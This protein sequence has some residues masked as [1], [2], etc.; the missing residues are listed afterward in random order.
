MQ[1]RNFSGAGRRWWL[2][3]GAALLAVVCS[4][5]QA[6]AQAAP[7]PAPGLLLI[8]AIRLSL[9]QNV[10]TLLQEQQVVTN[11]GSVLQQKG[12]FDPTAQVTLSRARTATTVPAYQEDPILAAG[13]TNVM[14]EKTDVTSNM[15][16][17]SK[18]FLNGWTVTGGYSITTTV[19]NLNNLLYD[20]QN[21][22]RET[23]GKLSFSV[24]APLLKNAGALA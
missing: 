10:N 2:C 5:Q 6:C 1:K 16:F 12:P 22:G 8:D 3:R 15:Y 11:E 14:Q 18:Q 13:I 7:Q 9:K 19:D 24:T 17:L 21:G 4:V 20:I 23:S